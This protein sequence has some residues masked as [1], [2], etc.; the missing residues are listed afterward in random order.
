MDL[1]AYLA[2]LPQKHRDQF[3]SRC[4]TSLGHLKNIAYGYKSCGESL[5]IDIERES[6]AKVRCEELRP[7]VDWKYLRGSA[8]K[9]LRA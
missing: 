7:D 8:S 2:E 4:K 6:G 1:K 5:A 3:A 9:E